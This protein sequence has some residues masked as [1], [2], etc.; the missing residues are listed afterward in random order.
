MSISAAAFSSNIDLSSVY[1]V[2]QANF[3]VVKYADQDS[4]KVA[5]PKGDEIN[6]EA[7]IS[8]DAM[9]MLKTQATNPQ[10]EEQ[11]NSR[12][13]S[14]ADSEKENGQKKNNY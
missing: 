11:D 3:N 6:D 14:N 1:N 13:N 2:R 10:N 9:A 4:S 7:I 12:A 8:S 5:D